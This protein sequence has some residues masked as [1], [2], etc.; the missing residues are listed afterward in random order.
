[1]TT[2]DMELVGEYARHSSEEAFATLVSRYVNLVYSVALRQVGDAHLA[3]EITQVVFILLARKAASLGPKT[4]LPGWLCRTARHASDNAL[5]IQRRRQHREQEAYMQSLVTESESDHWAQIAPLLSAAMAELGEKD[6][7][8][9]VLRFF[10]GRSFKEVGQSFGASE[11]AAKKRVNRA[12]EKLR[13]FFEK[14]GV[15]STVAIIGGALSANSVHAAPVA[16]AKSVTAV[17]ITKG[18]VASGS[19]MTIIEGVLKVMAWTKAK[20]A[21]TVGAGLL[22]T[23]GTTTVAITEIQKHKT[24]SW[25]SPNVQMRT[26]AETAPQVKI[27]PSKFDQRHGLAIDRQ[28]RMIGIGV[29]VVDVLQVAYSYNWARIVVPTELSQRRVDFIA[30]LPSGSRVA[31]KREVEGRFQVKARQETRETDVLLLKVARRNARGLK[32]TA[33][34]NGSDYN[35]GRVKFMGQPMSDFV[36]ILEQYFQTPVIDQ[37]GLAGEFDFSLAWNE[38]PDRKE[39]GRFETGDAGRTGP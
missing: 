4:I 37:T 22:L 5:K 17:A 15:S 10:N 11:E 26:L 20:M 14:R 29:A 32:P 16:L 39:S 31:L 28:D 12:L 8:A 1:M 19:T 2:D 6:H 33:I 25:Q 18:A 35:V 23:A 13:A 24:Y 34:H 30:N 38:Q 21:I 3:E 36:N 9:I 27:V 7:D